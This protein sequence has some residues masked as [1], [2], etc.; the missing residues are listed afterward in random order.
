MYSYPGEN[1]SLTIVLLGAAS[2]FT[3]ISSECN[4]FLQV[5]QFHGL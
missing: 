4:Q 5:V 3:L 2:K 1:G